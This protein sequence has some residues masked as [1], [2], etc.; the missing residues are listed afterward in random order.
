MF[1][2]SRLLI[3]TALLDVLA[4]CCNGNHHAP[5]EQIVG[6]YWEK[7]RPVDGDVWVDGFHAVL[8]SFTH[9][10]GLGF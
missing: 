6:S 5:L 1:S 9:I 7:A 8:W 2:R 10:F 3:D 4:L